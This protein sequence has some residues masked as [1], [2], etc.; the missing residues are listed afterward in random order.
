MMRLTIRM[1]MM[2]LRTGRMLMT[3]RT[4]MRTMMMMPSILSIS[5]RREKKKWINYKYL[6][7]SY[8]NKLQIPFVG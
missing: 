8:C 2:R 6:N 3:A 4:T 7:T 1:R 5:K